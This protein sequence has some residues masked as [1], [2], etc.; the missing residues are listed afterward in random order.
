[1]TKAKNTTTTSKAA[2]QPQ[3]EAKPDVIGVD[4]GAPDGDVGVT[5]I[6]VTTL[7]YAQALPEVAA[8]V[9]G[10][11]ALFMEGSVER[12]MSV[13]RR[14]MAVVL[15]DGVVSAKPVSTASATEA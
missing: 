15:V 12:F 2:T 8:D 6:N 5:M 1:M 4:P 11:D 7:A 9:K 3:T 10:D 14:V 13:D